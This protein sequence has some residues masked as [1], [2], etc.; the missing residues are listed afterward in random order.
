M[1]KKGL[2][3]I[4]LLAGVPAFAS[5]ILLSIDEIVDGAPAA[6]PPATEGVFDALYEAGNIAFDTEDGSRALGTNELLPLARA[7]GAQYLLKAVVA[8]THDGSP[9][10]PVVARAE[11]SFFTVGG[12]MLGSKVLTDDNRG[13][14]GQMDLKGLGFELG[15]RIGAEVMAMM[16][17][18]ESR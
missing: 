4:F 3:V 16:G 2:I 18:A 17:S 7:G 11:F 14:E 5:T 1:K 13:R 12:A 9:A 10:G 15:A 6:P 8:F